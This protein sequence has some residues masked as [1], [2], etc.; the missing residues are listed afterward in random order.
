M[1]PHIACVVPDV[2]G[3]DLEGE[4][5]RGFFPVVFGVTAFVAATTYTAANETDPEIICGV[6]DAAE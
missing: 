5:V 4:V 2:L 1:N 6:A 3:F